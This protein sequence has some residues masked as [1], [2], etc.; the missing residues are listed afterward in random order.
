MLRGKLLD[1]LSEIEAR[2]DFEEDLLPLNQKELLNNLNSIKHELH[3]LILESKQGNFFRN[4]LKVALVGLP[5]VGK[6]SILNRLIKKD[7]AIVTALPG[8]TRDLLES[9]IVLEGVP[10]TI[11]DTAGIR[12]TK[13]EVEKLGV[14]RTQKLLLKSDLIIFIFDISMGWTNE[15]KELFNQI[16]NQIPK[17]IVGNKADISVKKEG[18]NPDVIFSALT[19]QGEQSLINNLLTSCGH[20]NTHGIEIAL[21]ERQV[22]LVSSTINSLNRTLEVA[23]Q[24]LPWDFWTID[25]R[26]AIQNL[27][28]L[29]GDEISEALLDRIFS[30]FCIGK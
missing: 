2:I 15:T 27:G 30:R 9:E 26:D 18:V 29:T 12:E 20:N 14:I 11:I 17:I 16:P 10:I 22:D 23:N 8:T 21:N 3:N 7:R 19:G 1:Q 4:G 13:D 5:N 6:S 24:N 25:L 28:E